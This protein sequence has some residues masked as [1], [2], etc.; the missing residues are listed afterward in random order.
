M[1]HKTKRIIY[2]IAAAT[3]APL[4]A[5]GAI[6]C[7]TTTPAA[8]A[9]GA[10]STA[11][12]RAE[13]AQNVRLVGYNDL[14]GRE[15]LVVTTMSD[16]ANGSW[17]YVGHHESYLDDKPKMNPITGKEEWNGT[18]ILNV[19]DPSNPKLVWHIP[20][21]S[22]RNSRGVSVVYDYKFDGSGR[23]YLI[24]NSEALTEGETGMDL[25]YQIFDITDRA[26]DPSKITLVSEITGTP[27]NSCGAG[28]GGKFIIRAHKGWWSPVTG[29]FY[30]ASGEPGFRNVIVQIFDLKNPREPKFLGRSWLPGLREGEP[31][32]EGQYTHHPVVD[33]DNKRL[34]IG[35][36]NAG[37]QIAGFDISDPA[38]QKL[39][40]SLD[41]NP[42]FRG[43]HTVSPIVYDS[44]PNIGPQGLPRTYALVVDEAGGAAD[45]APCENPIRAASYMV[46]ITN[47]AKPTVVSVWQVPVGDFCKRGGRFGPHQNA[48]TVNGKINR[49]ENKMAWIAYFNAG[50]RVVDLS[51]PF[52][53]KEIGHYLPKTNERSHP[54]TKDQPTVIQM[55]DVDIDHRGLAYASDRVGT[56][57]FILEYTGNVQQGTK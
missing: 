39:L 21:D 14:Q 42:P 18:S 24:R 2:G 33:E 7:G 20:N 48:E 38:K 41:M 22:N 53:L 4:L 51:D 49:F 5:A 11:D 46:D 37:G 43:P 54:I 30:A 3:I 12:E 52:S 15:S 9:A 35:Y 17:V 13:S 28:C 10:S 31:G 44:V 25:K 40:W 36:R 27:P 1:T 34:Y 50:V 45:S 8:P 6:S 32:Y 57:L 55:N 47:E 23:D 26:T 29:Y 56:G 16:Q 19:D